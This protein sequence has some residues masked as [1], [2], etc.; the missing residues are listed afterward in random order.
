MVDADER[1]ELDLNLQIVGGRRSA[2]PRSPDEIAAVQNAVTRMNDPKNI[3]KFVASFPGILRNSMMSDK[4]RAIRDQRNEEYRL[5]QVR[6]AEEAGKKLG[7]ASYQISEPATSPSEKLVDPSATTRGAHKK[8]PRTETTVILAATSDPNVFQG[9]VP[10]NVIG[11]KE[12]T[13]MIKATLTEQQRRWLTGEEPIPTR[14]N[15]DHRSKPLFMS[16]DHQ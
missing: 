14:S 6:G 12:P 15:G 9:F 7:P 10:E 2:Y 13:V 3:M 4:E 16:K 11:K 8:K 5:T 1:K